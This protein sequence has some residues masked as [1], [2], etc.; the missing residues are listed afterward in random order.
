MTQRS[1]RRARFVVLAA[2]AALLAF[3]D[4]GGALAQD[5]APATASLDQQLVDKFSPVSYLKQGTGP[6]DEE[7]EP[8]LPAPVD[9]TFHDP[10]VVLREAPNREAIKSDIAGS[11]L[12][13]R[14]PD[15]YVDL[16]GH[17]R[18]P[19]CGYAEHFAQVMGKQKPAVYA[20]IATEPGKPGL[21]VQYWF[22]YYFNDFNNLHEGDWEMIQLFFDADSVAQAL[23]Q[24]PVS[25][26]FAQHDGGEIADWND[27]KL[28]KEGTHPVTFP[29]RG[30]HASYYGPAIWLG[31]GEQRSGFG[32][33]DTTGPSF[34]VAPEVRLIQGDITGAA[35]PR[36]WAT[37]AGRWGELDTGF[38]N[39]PTGPTQKPQWTAPVSWQEGLRRDSLAVDTAELL[40]PAPTQVFC[41]VVK[42]GSALFALS[43]PYPV[44]V[45]GGLAIVLIGALLLLRLAWPYLR[46]A[47]RLYRRHP[48]TFAAIG[49]LVLPVTILVSGFHFL[50][51]YNA[52]FSH[53]V[54]FDEDSEVVHAILALA[55]YIQQALLLFL[56]TP[57]TIQAVAALATGDAT[58]AGAAIRGAAGK[59]WP[60]VLATLR[61]FLIEIGLTITIV[62]IPWAIHRF[63]AWTFVPQTVV[64]DGA[65]GGAALAASRR[66][67]RGHWWRTAA[68]TAVLSFV[69]VAIGPLAGLLLLIPLRAPVELA[70][71]GG[72]AIYAITQPLTMMAATLFY[73]RLQGK[74]WPAAAT[75]GRVAPAPP[76][77]SAPAP[78]GA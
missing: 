1:V 61:A 36:A 76:A 13:D 58:S 39:G 24:E 8:Y 10:A 19:G 67:T 3:V 68:I 27:P 35:D 54:G 73:L 32:C 57:A 62:G 12:F 53:L 60:L 64:L 15:Y 41:D 6:C 71:L 4:L 7:G 31:W 2:L 56:I 16:P 30:S 14:G 77:A 72:A 44:P 70:N 48:G 75:I 34:R 46:G 38:F 33:D 52:A 25:V 45:F 18:T 66:A 21:A 63:V 5:A 26:A 17:P 74:P 9:V 42:T 55:L 22:F 40:G 23:R 59:I 50:L 78:T 43:V 51:E 69:A 47:W 49:A 29:S 20:H 28:E 37:F 11:D 65:R